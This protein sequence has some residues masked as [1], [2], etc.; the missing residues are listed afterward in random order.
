MRRWARGISIR[1]SPTE[2][3]QVAAV[4]GVRPHSFWEVGDESTA[5]IDSG[6]IPLPRR[7]W[8]QARAHRE[9]RR[10]GRRRRED[11]FRV[12]TRYRGRKGSPVTMPTLAVRRSTPSKFVV[13]RHRDS[14]VILPLLLH[15][16]SG[17][18]VAHEC[19]RRKPPPR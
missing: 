8:R 1:R 5:P 19:E 9:S 13:L 4:P 3:C 6:N 12:L 17:M 2:A 7:R 10:G 14:A 11:L 16:V 18:A 15:A